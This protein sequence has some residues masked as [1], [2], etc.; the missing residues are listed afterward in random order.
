MVYG[1]LF[2][3][4]SV[5]SPVSTNPIIAS[6]RRSGGVKF[7]GKTTF[8]SWALLQKIAKDAK[9]KTGYLRFEF[10]SVLCYLCDLL[11]I[12]AGDLVP[13]ELENVRDFAIFSQ[14]DARFCEL[15]LRVPSGRDV[16][17]YRITL[18]FPR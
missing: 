16:G 7:N 14:L 9:E 13:S 2:A 5:T 12:F 17:L 18:P 1:R 6:A 11:L 10:A 4:D 3:R 8:S 15:S